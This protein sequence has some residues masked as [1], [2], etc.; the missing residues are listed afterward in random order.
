[1]STFLKN[2]WYVAALYADVER[3]LKPV[4]L[5]SE[6]IVLHRTLDGKPVALED[7][8]YAREIT[9]W[10]ETVDPFPV[11]KFQGRSRRM[12][13]SRPPERGLVSRP[14]RYSKYSYLDP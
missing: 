7:A 11:G 13:E 9:I 8:S 1:M 10:N 5:L 3:S 12:N 6:A 14:W 2:A 4:K